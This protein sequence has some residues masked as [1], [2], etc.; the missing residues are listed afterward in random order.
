MTRR[1]NSPAARP[2]A[3]T[4]GAPSP[5]DY[6][7]AYPSS[8]RVYE[9]G[10]HGIRVPFRE[11]RLSGGE[12]PLRVYDTAGPLAVDVRQGAPS[13]RGEWIASRPVA[14]SPEPFAGRAFGDLVPGALRNRPLRAS[15][16]R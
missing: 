15:A 8:F 7:D 1:P 16:A 13:V 5:G 9:T 4:N 14:P 3:S 2:P 12:P 11:I 10:D 6:G